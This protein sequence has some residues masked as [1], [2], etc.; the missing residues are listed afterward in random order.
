M[1]PLPEL[2]IY[3]YHLIFIKLPMLKRLFQARN[4]PALRFLFLFFAVSF[5]MHFLVPESQGQDQAPETVAAAPAPVIVNGRELFRV[6]GVT[7]YP[8]KQRATVIAG[9]IKALAEDRSIDPKS[10]QSEKEGDIIY[11]KAGKLVAMGLIEADAVREGVTLEVLEL[12]IRTKIAEAIVEYRNDRTPR[13]LLINSGYALLATVITALLLWGILHLFAWLDVLAQKRIKAR[14]ERLEAKSH[15][16]F[17]A[18][19]IWDM[20]SGLLKTAK[21][22]GMLVVIYFYLNLVLGLYPWTRWF[23]QQL[24]TFTVDP[25]RVIVQGIVGA[26]PNIFFLVILFFIT[27]Y[28]LKIT[29][30]FFAGIDRGS[31]HVAK[32]DREWGLPTYRI[33]RIMIIAFVVIVAYPYIPGSSSDAFKGVSIFLGVIFSLGS[34]S[35]LTNIIAGYTIT[36][37]RAFKIGDRI[38]IDE[39]TGEVI[40]R[41]VLVTR[42]RSLKNEEIVIP[43]STILNSN[44]INYSTEAK[45]NGLILHTTVGIGYEVPWRQVEAMLLLAADRTKGIRPLPK[46]FVLQ[47]SLGDFA[48]NYE[49]NIY[50]DD[51]RQMMKLYSELHRNILDVFNEYNVQIMTPNYEQDTQQPKVVPKDQWYAPPAK[52]NQEKNE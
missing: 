44:I 50:I 14:I 46:P 1:S 24:F 27:R 43:N 13:T 36:Y 40:E 21:V 18:D 41:S 4:K 8:A 17:D 5:S 20:M 22:L 30:L 33:V 37:R 2:G 35:V 7:S 38:K 10:L 9:R 6:G 31:I 48:I 47:Q 51:A 45:A 29:R 12:T 42:L 39:F 52:A 19:Q 49:L 15:Y 23:A 26:L 28:I 11:I 3:P 16:I 32:F 34:S 25:L